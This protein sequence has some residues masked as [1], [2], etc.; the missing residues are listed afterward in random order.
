LKGGTKYQIA[1]DHYNFTSTSASTST[2]SIRFNENSRDIK[3]LCSFFTD[4]TRDNT[5]VP[6]D[7]NTKT[8]T[9]HYFDY[10]N[11]LHVSSQF[12]IGSVMMPQ[13]KMN[14]TEVFLENMRAV[15]GLR[16]G[17]VELHP[18][19][20][21]VEDFQDMAFVSILSLEMTEGMTLQSNDGKK[22]LSGLSSEQLPI[23]CVYTYTN[24]AGSFN[25]KQ[26]NVMVISTRLLVIESGQQTYVEI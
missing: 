25:N 12:Q 21:T 18:R 13:N 1:F 19:I 22:L 6:T 9:S 4:T 3:A 5:S 16:N 14:T 20:L 17:N 15:S 10:Q 2:A 26:L 8:K 11:L 23:S 7:F 24:N